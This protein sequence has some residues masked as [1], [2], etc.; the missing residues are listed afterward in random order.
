MVLPA[1]DAAA[2]EHLDDLIGL[3]EQHPDP[4]VQERVLQSLRC[5]D[6]HIARSNQVDT[7]SAQRSETPA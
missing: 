6:R 2:V 4:A 1:G 7:R 5:V 3:F